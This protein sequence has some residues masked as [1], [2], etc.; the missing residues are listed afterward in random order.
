MAYSTATGVRPGANAPYDTAYYGNVVDGT[1]TG[2]ANGRVDGYIPIV[3]SR[4]MLKDFYVSTIF[5]EISNTN[6]E[7]EIKSGGDMI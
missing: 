1:G 2:S 6:Y 3:F 5:S 7:G 4:K